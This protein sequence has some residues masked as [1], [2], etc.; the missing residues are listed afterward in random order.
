MVSILHDERIWGRS[1]SSWTSAVDCDDG[2]DVIQAILQQASGC[3][4]ET[5]MIS[6][7]FVCPQCGRTTVTNTELD[8]SSNKNSRALISLVPTVRLLEKTASDDDTHVKMESE[9]PPV[10]LTLSPTNSVTD[11]SAVLSKESY[12]N[13]LNN[14][15][16]SG[17]HDVF[18]VKDKT[19][20]E[21]VSPAT[22][23]MGSD[24]SNVVHHKT[25]KSP[26]VLKSALTNSRVITVKGI[27]KPSQGS[28]DNLKKMKHNIIVGK[29]L[30]TGRIVKMK[31]LNPI[32]L[33]TSIFAN[34]TVSNAQ[35]PSSLCISS[36][37][38][39]GNI[40]SSSSA[41]TSG[42]TISLDPKIVSSRS[43][44]NTE[45]KMIVE[46]LNTD[47]NTPTYSNVK[48]KAENDVSIV[49]EK[50]G[51]P[52]VQILSKK[53]QNAQNS[54]SLKENATL[55]SSNVKERTQKFIVTSIT[56]P[57]IE[58]YKTS[59]SHCN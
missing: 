10:N 36:V 32:M 38:G 45:A 24:S 14:T 5:D 43:L 31:V 58:K 56:C 21:I 39:T 15:T 57:S 50:G 42:R 19:N 49:F 34:N 22:K 52:D 12:R 40:A 46:P 18:L 26:L 23:L 29:Q 48:R 30:D 41:I 35:S 17:T 11:R 55:K 6:S 37:M 7:A 33:N 3:H 4:V 20:C 9:D 54:S 25:I 8:G 16:D 53:E 47:K 59:K 51:E 28:F 13:N 1:K 44:T 27:N 2:S